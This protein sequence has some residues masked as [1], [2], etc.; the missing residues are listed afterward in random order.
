M[1][2]QIT[3]GTTLDNL[4]REAKRWLKALRADVAEARARL[5]RAWPHAPAL[6][7]LR[8]VQRALALEFGLPG[9]TAL[10]DRVAA[11]SPTRRYERV[12]EAVVVAYRTPE[13]AAMRIVW[14]HFGHRRTWDAMRRYIRLDLGKREQPENADDDQ[15]TLA[16]AQYLVARSQGFESWQALTEFAT[17]VPSAQARSLAGRIVGAY[18]LDDAGAQQIAITTLDWDELAAFMRDNGTP[19][20]HASGQMTDDVLE[21]FARIE[22]I[23]DLDLSGS[24]AITDDGLRHLARLPRLRRV[25]L[26]GCS[27]ITDRGLHVFRRTPT[28]ESVDL[29]WT[30]VTDAGIAH[31]GSCERLESVNLSGTATGDGAIAALAGKSQLHTLRSGSGVT[32]AGL[33]LLHELPVFQRWQ[34][35]DPR[36]ALLSPDARPN[37][38]SLRGPFTDRGFAHLVGLDGLYALDV[39]DGKL[40]ITGAAL[41]PL[42]ELPH[43]SWLAFDATDESMPYIAALPHLRFLLCQDTTAGDDGFVALSKS[44]TIE[45]IWGRRCYNLRRRGFVAL[46]DMPALGY[47]SVSCK[48]VDDVGLSALPRFPVLRELMPMDVP[49]DGYRYVGQCGAL[50]SLVLM[51]CRDTTDAATRHITRLTTLRKYFASYT[52]ITDVTPELLSGTSSLEEITF[53]SCAGLTDAGIATL[54]RLPRLRELRVGGMP[55]VTPGVAKAFSPSVKVRHLR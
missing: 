11:E 50:E 40:A 38:L 37:F 12:A 14:E 42:V 6:P 35:G 46:A 13:P 30:R 16:D 27:R 29:A 33:A 28:L 54:A 55:N 34:G 5:E 15:V 36:M 24:S 2:R 10:K 9:W 32:D 18:S 22:S 49:D 52:R 7:T 17:N 51:Y 8:D 53:D 25:N 39:D 41:A 26:S 1:S 20:L 43:L 4:K 45:Y 44:R 19:G 47:L 21:Q 48:N 31:L 23:S 3:P